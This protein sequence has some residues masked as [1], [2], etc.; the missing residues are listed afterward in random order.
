M[1]KTEFES[2]SVQRPDVIVTEKKRGEV[3]LS[4]NV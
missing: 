1:R 2:I 3:D 4:K